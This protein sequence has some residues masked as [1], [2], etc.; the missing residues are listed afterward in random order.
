M[1]S[2]SSISNV[3]SAFAGIVGGLP[4]FPVGQGYRNDEPSF[5]SHVEGHQTPIPARDDLSG[6]EGE[7]ERRPSA[8]DPWGPKYD[9]RCDLNAD[10]A[11][12]TL[13]PLPFKSLF[14]LSC[15]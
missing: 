14:N 9:P 4:L 13:D 1:I 3:S 11:T 7:R 15:E 12:N 2:S 5:T 10:N 6:T 8:T